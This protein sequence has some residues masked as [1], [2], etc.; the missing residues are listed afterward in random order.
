M[1]GDGSAAVAASGMHH[2]LV[3][4]NAQ[5]VG[6]LHQSQSQHLDSI[7]FKQWANYWFE[8][9]GY[10]DDGIADHLNSTRQLRMDSTTAD[11]CC[12][13]IIY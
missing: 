10:I 1:C 9:M 13:R 8:S 12:C 2:S 6:A 11:L 3:E 5:D 7:F 4:G